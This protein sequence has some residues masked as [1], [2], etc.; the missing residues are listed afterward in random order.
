LLGAPSATV[1][2][3]DFEF[4]NAEVKVLASRGCPEIELVG[5]KVGPFEEG[6]EYQVLFWVARELE[7]AGIARIQGEGLLDAVE[8]NKVQWKERVQPVGRVSSLPEDFYPGLRRYLADLKREAGKGAERVREY[9]KAVRLARDIVN[10]RLKKVVSLSS[11][12]A[13]TD[14]FLNNLAREERLLY[15]R[16]SRIIGDWRDSILRGGGEP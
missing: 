10:C 5:L 3:V 13:Q 8:L 14:Q 16:L 9:E 15:D 2:D 12:P 11:S 4:E 7:G 1:G 6:R